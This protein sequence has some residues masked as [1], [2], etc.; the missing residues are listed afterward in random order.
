MSCCTD[1]HKQKLLDYYNKSLKYSSTYVIEHSQD[2][3]EKNLVTSTETT[4]PLY[5]F[6]D[7]AV[8]SC[9]KL[10]RSNMPSFDEPNPSRTEDYYLPDSA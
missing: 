6:N 10:D 5:E 7:I 4:S 8:K 2:N 3:E 1:E 9:N